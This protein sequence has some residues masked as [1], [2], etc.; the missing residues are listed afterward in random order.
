MSTFR[1]VCTERSDGA[2][3]AAQAERLWADGHPEWLNVVTGSTHKG[4]D[5]EGRTI[6]M[7][8]EPFAWSRRHRPARWQVP[9]GRA[10]LLISLGVIA[11]LAAA[12][13]SGSSA[14]SSTTS[15]TSSSSTSAGSAVVV[16]VVTISPYGQIL[17]D[18]SGKPL[19]TLSGACTGTCTSAWPALTVSAGVKP[20]GGAGVKGTLSA[21]KQA[22][23]KYQ[24]TYNGSPLYTF[25][26][27][28]PD[29]VTG[30]GIAGF[31]V[32]KISGSAT[33]TGSSTTTTST[34][35]NGY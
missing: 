29:H 26:Q 3:A 15:T 24:V 13:S 11:L 35:S 10:L 5:A 17:V 18:S 33:P 2:C 30:Q 25:V 6:A 8:R 28:S 9:R 32:A 19:Y 12:C 22:D 21:V 27:D 20:T 23:G 14:S 4:Y 1:S 7:R 34:K 31:S 16:K